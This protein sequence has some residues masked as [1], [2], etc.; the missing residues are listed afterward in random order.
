[1]SK[2]GR[3]PAEAPEAL[4]IW[5]LLVSA[6]ANRLTLLANDLVRRPSSVRVRRDLRSCMTELARLLDRRVTDTDSGNVISLARKLR[7]RA[8]TA[9]LSSGIPES[10]P[11]PQSA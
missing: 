9:A 5:A 11:P 8:I 3:T 4:V 6:Y 2:P 7:V 10:G 1:M